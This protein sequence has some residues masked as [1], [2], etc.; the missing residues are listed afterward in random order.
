M[1]KRLQISSLLVLARAGPL[2]LPRLPPQHPLQLPPLPTIAVSA[3]FTLAPWAKEG[4]QDLPGGMTAAE[5]KT[6]K[7]RAAQDPDPGHRQ[8]PER[9]T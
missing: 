7:M 1:L 5:E 3:G 2:L 9:R 4:T 8:S 6:P